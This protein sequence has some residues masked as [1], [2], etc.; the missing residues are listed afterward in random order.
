VIQGFPLGDD[1]QVDLAL[2]SFPVVA[3]GAQLVLGRRHGCDEPIDFDPESILFFRGEVVGRP[4]SHVFLA[5]SD[6]MSTGQIVLGVGGRE[7]RISSRGGDGAALERG[8]ISV[9][10]T[11]G[12][13]GSSL[14]VPFCGVSSEPV[15]SSSARGVTGLP[16]LRHLE[17]AVETDYEFFTL[18]GDVEAA[19]TYVIEMYAQLSDIY[20]RDV[21]TWVEIVFVR[22]WDD[23]DDLFNGSDPLSE[24]RSYWNA[25]MDDVH[26]DIAQLFSGRRDYPFGGQAYLSAL[27]GDFGYSVVGYAAGFFPDPTRPSPYNYDIRVTAHEVGHNCGTLHTH[28][29]SK[30]DSCDDPDSEAQRGTIMSYCSQTWS[31]GNSNTDNY[32]HSAIQSYM[33]DH[34]L[35]VPCVVHDCNMNSTSDLMDIAGGDS[36]DVNANG[37]PDE[38]EDCNENGTLDNQDIDRGS[39][40][41]LNGNGVP[42]ECEPDC[43]G[44]DVPDDLDI[45]LGTSV[46]QFGNDIPDECEADCN[47]NGI[48]D[49]SEIQ[50]DMTL[51]I[52]R[53]AILDQ[54]QDCDGD[55][56]TD[57]QTLDGAHGI[58]IAS[59]L[60]GGTPVRRFYADT[61]VQ[62]A[63]SSGSEVAFGQDV[64][65]VDDGRVLVSSGADHRVMEFD[66]SGQFV[67]DLVPSGAGGLVFPTG[68]ALASDGVLLVAS[69]DTNTVL[70]Y[71]VMDGIPLGVFV[72][73]DAGGLV[74][75]FGMTFGPN[76]NLFVTSGDGQV[77]EFDGGSGALVGLFVSGADNGGLDQPRGLTFKSD[78][79][80]LVTSFGTNETLEYDGATGQPM[81]KWAQAGTDTVLTQISPWGIR[82]GPNGNVFISR[83]G[84]D[85]GSED[86]PEG[87]ETDDDSI[88]ALH[89]SKALVYE[90]DVRNGN[91]IRSY[92][93]GHDHDLIFATGFAFIPGWEIDCNLNLLPDACDIA[94][95]TSQDV[96]GNGTPDKCEVDCNAN[97]VFD[98]LDII[99]F[100]TS[101]DCNYN[102]TPDEC[103]IAQGT[104]S[105]VN[106]DLIPDECQPPCETDADCDDGDECTSDVCGDALLCEHVPDQ[107]P[108]EGDA[109]GDGTVDPLDAGFVLARFGC[110]VGTGDPDCDSAD[111]NGDGIVDPLDSGFVLARFGECP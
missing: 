17:L 27:C 71:D 73:A 52:D 72:E 1:L 24:F 26:R 53:N 12:A 105:D 13:P 42:D 30:L 4:Q 92:I 102:L 83:T 5:L 6:H 90:F 9:F 91:F 88:A 38:C 37:V 8:L 3:Q 63:S 49:Y 18:F 107:C 22:I 48:S 77:F 62:T 50:Q 23:P 109:N 29:F 59:G 94:S 81:G 69:R 85:F 41:D 108:C 57:I 95:G 16:N 44:N 55:G 31:G 39:S 20:M 2:K 101:I 75:P 93:L 74:A 40:Q 33:D 78:G 51:D 87:D 80:L 61:G 99:P 79:H 103:D 45:L 10:P 47:A 15:H 34:I 60:E 106:G 67:G 70:A 25:N 7:Y 100:G 36:S 58:W 89:L 96:D 97:G 54:C 86:N 111:Q 28:D 46:D 64:L 104:S 82:V 21:D 19:T 98:R 110:S 35:S 56:I 14:P 11:S 76:G 84:E 66:R 43:N 32:F 68:L 65:V